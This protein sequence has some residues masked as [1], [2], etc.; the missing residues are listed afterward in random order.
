MKRLLMILFA[1]LLFVN[2]AVVAYATNDAD[3]NYTTSYDAQTGILTVTANIVDIKDASGITMVEYKILY[4]P[5]LLE[6]VDAK[7]NMP[8]HWKPLA[9]AKPEMA[10]DLSRLKNPG[11][12]WWAIMVFDPDQAVFDDNDLSITMTFKVLKNTD[13]D[14]AFNN[15][16]IANG[17]LQRLTGPS[18]VIN[19]DFDENLSE[20]DIGISDIESSVDESAA[21]NNNSDANSDNNSTSIESGNTDASL[22]ISVESNEDVDNTSAVTD[23]E[24]SNNAIIFVIIG[25]A[26]V[27]AIV[28]AVVIFR[29][30][31]K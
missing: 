24:N 13:S 15:V 10:E 5:K 4:D 29:K 21:E 7:P 14:I 11:E 16:C 22:S 6:Y 17:A 18:T 2:L 23:N 1:A 20:P 26:I 3:I 31:K 9:D 12:F 27:G 8:D 28:I 19:I 30:S 25:I